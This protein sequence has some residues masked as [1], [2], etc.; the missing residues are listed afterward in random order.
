MYNKCTWG[1]V[2][3]EILK[4]LDE[5]TK[6]VK[7]S[8]SLNCVFFY[9]GECRDYMKTK[10]TP[11]IF[12]GDFNDNE[13]YIDELLI[14]Y[15]ISNSDSVIKR[16]IDSQHYI[17]LSRLLDI[18]FNSLVAIFF[19]CEPNNDDGYLYVFRFPSAL[20]PS[21][22]HFIDY[23]NNNSNIHSCLPNYIN[24]NFKLINHSYLN[25]RIKAQSGGFIL[26]SGENS[27]SIRESLYSR[28]KIKASLKE[29]VREELKIYFNIDRF[30]LFPEKQNSREKIISEIKKKNNLKCKINFE[31]EDKDS[32][33]LLEEIYNYINT[34]IFFY[35]VEGLKNKEKPS[36]YQ[37]RLYRKLK[38]T[39]EL[40]IKN[41]TS[42]VNIKLCD[43]DT[44][45]LMAHFNTAVEKINIYGGYQ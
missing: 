30:V 23:D 7:E 39:L 41:L 36:H 12:R 38:D 22:N 32:I 5:V 17:E 2:F 19:A 33:R 8:H 11:N 25:E 34:L 37:L 45:K 29:K 42:D 31:T 27:S 15:N 26:F 9:R 35:K 14:D 44:N 18:S 40:L 43:K 4:I 1:E 28:I 20:S 13:E 6:F 21:S 10:L 3:M 24:D 16:M